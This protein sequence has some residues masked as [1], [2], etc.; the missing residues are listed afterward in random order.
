MMY[1]SLHLVEIWW[2][3]TLFT[4][5]WAGV[6]SNIGYDKSMNEIQPKK[7]A[8]ALWFFTFFCV[9]VKFCSYHSKLF[10]CHWGNHM[11]SP[12]SVKQPWRIKV[13]V[14]YDLTRAGT[15]FINVEISGIITYWMKCGMTLLIHSQ[16]SIIPLQL[17]NGNVVSSHTVWSALVPIMVCCLTVP[18]H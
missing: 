16:T 10:Y 8:R 17:E 18:G 14:S 5:E 2:M 3:T 13:N 9:I 7:Y 15:P 11:I 1:F 12:V 4:L 6:G